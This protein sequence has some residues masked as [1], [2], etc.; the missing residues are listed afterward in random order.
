MRNNERI[1]NDES[2][3]FRRFVYNDSTKTTEHL[4]DSY[5]LM[6]KSWL[7]TNSAN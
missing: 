6:G 5:G 2:A 7:G 4:I 1:F 3:F